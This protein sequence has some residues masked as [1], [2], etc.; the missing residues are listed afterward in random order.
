[1]KIFT[2][3]SQKDLLKKQNIFVLICEKLSS[4]SAKSKKKNLPLHLQ[5]QKSGS[6]Y[7]KAK[8]Q[9]YL[10]LPI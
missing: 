10:V 6:T 7:A 8:I 3:F 9:Y 1:M 5:E 2:W 4:P